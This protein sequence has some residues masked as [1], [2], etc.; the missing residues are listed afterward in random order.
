[1]ILWAIAGVPLGTYNIVEE[2][3]VALQVQPQILTLLS[4][5][6]WTQCLKEMPPN[7][8]NT[9]C[10]VRLYPSLPDIWAANRNESR[11]PVAADHDGYLKCQSSRCWC[12]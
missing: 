12:A 10:H 11:N 1:M 4:L 6:T 8:F 5:A 2:F 3:N 7:S 9:V